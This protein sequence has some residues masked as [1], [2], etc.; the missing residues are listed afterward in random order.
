MSE[1]KNR[2]GC[3]VSGTPG[4]GAITLGAA[5]AS[6]AVHQSFT[7]AY[8]ANATVDLL[9]EDGS[10]WEIARDCAYDDTAGTVTRGTLEDSSTGAVLDLSSAAKVYVTHTAQRASMLAGGKFGVPVDLYGADPTGS[11][12]S[13]AAINAAMTAAAAN[14]TNTI[15]LSGEYLIGSTLSSPDGMVVR[16]LGRSTT[17]LVKAFN[18]TLWEYGDYP[19]FMDFGI[20]GQ[21]ATY[22]GDIFIPS[23]EG[24]RNLNFLRL[25]I[26]YIDGVALELNEPGAGIIDDVRVLDGNDY[27]YREINGAIGDKTRYISWRSCEVARCKGAVYSVDG[28]RDCSYDIRVGECTEHAYYL[29]GEHT[30][31]RYTSLIGG[32][33]GS[34]FYVTAS[35]WGYPLL[36]CRISNN[37]VSPPATYTGDPAQ[38]YIH[39]TTARVD[40]TLLNA[41][42]V[43]SAATPDV[44]MSHVAGY[45]SVQQIQT[46]IVGEVNR[47]RLLAQS[48]ELLG[49]LDMS[50]LT[51]GMAID[52]NVGGAEPVNFLNLTTNH[53]EHLGGVFPAVTASDRTLQIWENY[54]RVN[55]ASGNRVITL[56]AAADVNN[57]TYYV[58][59]TDSGSNTVTLTPAG[60]ETINGAATYVL[61]NQYQHVMVVS[62]ASNW[63]VVSE[64]R[65]NGSVTYAHMQ[66]V[67]ATDKLLGRATAGSGDVEEITCTAAGRALLDDADAAAQRAT[68]SAGYT[69]PV[70]A[71][72]STP[73]A[74]TVYYIATLAAVAANLTYNVVKGFIPRAGVIKAAQ[75]TNWCG[76]APSSENWSLYIRIN[77]TT[78]YL[79]Q[80][81]ASTAT[82]N[83]SW[84]NT[85][86]DIS[87]SQGDTWAIKIVCPAWVTAPTSVRFGG[88]IY[89]E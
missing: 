42:I 4:T 67:S 48:P 10:A 65:L 2:V 57:H 71:G 55:A 61:S 69:L 5:I 3:A 59:K 33:N 12:D 35:N 85:S 36:Q 62:D 82:T 87:V 56:P 72:G 81:V 27:A 18:G 17:K 79:I 45:L 1:L 37:L 78:D 52:V 9:I 15:W 28:S 19:T 20:D 50:T 73:V 34:A 84:V 51:A 77:D 6:P 83:R 32:C 54:C 53:I 22:T 24:Y 88:H 38:I 43:A 13:A 80:T 26:Q 11:V 25:T 46:L 31:N 7:T 70:V 74:S 58:I 89:I 16:G 40:M 29:A 44:A 23:D 76:T 47:V 8:G 66:D 60:A 30:N 14:G 39:N 49:D 41:S 75:I 63:F 86:L 64:Y 68:L 21:S